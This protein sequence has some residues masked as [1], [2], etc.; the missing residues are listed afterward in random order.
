MIHTSH[1][2]TSW[3][4]LPSRALVIAALTSPATSGA[5]IGLCQG[6][7]ARCWLTTNRCILANT[8]LCPFGI[9]LRLDA[10]CSC[11]GPCQMRLPNTSYSARAEALCA[12]A[13]LAAGLLA[14]LFVVPLPPCASLPRL[15]AL[16]TYFGAF[17]DAASLPAEGR[18]CAQCVCTSRAAPDFA[19][20]LAPAARTATCC[21]PSAGRPVAL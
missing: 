5:Y 13:P 17:F 15:P 4:R 20:A 12:A 1:S 16:A 6:A 19:V 3:L 9:A 11:S 8:M 18:A 21:A 7:D 2:A 10:A 14:L